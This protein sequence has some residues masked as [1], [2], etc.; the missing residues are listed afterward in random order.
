M[1]ITFDMDIAVISEAYKENVN[2]LMVIAQNLKYADTEYSTA[3]SVEQNAWRDRC[4]AKLKAVD[5]FYLTDE[6]LP[7]Y[8]VS[9]WVSDVLRISNYMGVITR[10]D[11]YS[12]TL[13]YTPG[14]I[15]RGNAFK[16][17]S[18]VFKLVTGKKG[19]TL[20]RKVEGK[21][22]MA[23]TLTSTKKEKLLNTD[24]DERKK[25]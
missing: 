14:W 2:D 5:A 17:L 12:C 1:K 13:H 11:K 16:E 9:D 8:E 24:L 10:G 25:S 7:E 19:W 3:T 6:I 18:R 20:S 4:V 21:E 23:V 22:G 15:N